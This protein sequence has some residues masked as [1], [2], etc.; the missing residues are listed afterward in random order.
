LPVTQGFAIFTYRVGGAMNYLAHLFL[1]GQ[2][3]ELMIGNFIADAV[4][5]RQYKNYS[6]KVREGI[7]LHRHI[8]TYTDSHPVVEES[9]SRLRPKY[10]KYAPI[11][12]DI[13][14]DHF[15]ALNWNRYST[16]QL[17]EYSTHVYR[18]LKQNLDEL[19][20]KSV[21]FLGYMMRNDILCAYGTKEGVQQV[22][23]GM[24]YRASFQ[25]NME[26]AT[27]ELSEH[28]S[29]FEKEFTEFFPQLQKHVDTL[30]LSGALYKN[31]E[32]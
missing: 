3:E 32:A 2:S 29:A 8:D 12:V 13:F 6:D 16:S 14:Y 17:D 1:S 5:G 31:A 30:L 10:R 18:I 24:A 25:S 21:Q 4:K 11:I 15:L 20:L 26:H 27:N 22:L 23:E 19:P 7:L 28:Y 9:K